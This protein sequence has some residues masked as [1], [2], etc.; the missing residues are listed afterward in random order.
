MHPLFRALRGGRR[1][2]GKLTRPRGIE[3]SVVKVNDD[4][5]VQKHANAELCGV[6]LPAEPL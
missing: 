2:F 6:I 1:K 3:I 4:K 5:A